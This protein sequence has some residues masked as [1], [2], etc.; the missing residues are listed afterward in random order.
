MIH[1]MPA[2]TDCD[3]LR[4]DSHFRVLRALEEN[5]H[6]SQRELAHVL[7]VSVAKVNYLL[8]GLVEKGHIKIEAFRRSGDKLNKIAYL[9]TPEGLSNRMALTRD[10]L[11]RKNREYEA[12][13]AEIASLR[14]ACNPDGDPDPTHRAQA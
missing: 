1:P 11:E 4:Q 3:Q 13:Q 5:P 12:L 9:L 6:L 2:P 7:G 14:A 8:N 10:Y